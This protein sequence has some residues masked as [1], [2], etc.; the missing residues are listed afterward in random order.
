MGWELSL[1]CW[2]QLPPASKQTMT[3]RQH[4]VPN[5]LPRDDL[6][7]QWDCRQRQHFAFRIFMN[8]PSLRVCPI[9]STKRLIAHSGSD[10][11]CSNKSHAYV[12]PR[13][14]SKQRARH[15]SRLSALLGMV[16]LLV[17]TDNKISIP[18]TMPRGK[19]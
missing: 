11:S 5:K 15:I 19:S 18:D 4:S 1:T 9:H 2:R 13:D 8:S 3:S 12:Q 10:Q 6:Q 17:P 7:P 14:Q 16:G